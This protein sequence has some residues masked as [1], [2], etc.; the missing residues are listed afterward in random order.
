MKPGEKYGEPFDTPGGK[1]LKFYASQRI[2]LNKV[3]GKGGLVHQINEDG[4]EEVVGHY[5]RVIVKKNRRNEPC[6][7]PLEIPI[8]YREYFPDKAKICYDLA[9]KLQVITTRRG[10]LTWKDD[11]GNII[12]QIDGESK[13]LQALREREGLKEY[14][15]FYCEKLAKDDKNLKRKNT[16]KVPSSILQMAELHD[17]NKKIDSVEMTK[18]EAV[19]KDV[20]EDDE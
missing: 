14:L 17:P 5:A 20:G 16:I 6:L 19:I 8:Y 7:E 13:M 11:D 1:A 3:G 10:I 18:E 2:W 15:A 12:V 9:R 4:I